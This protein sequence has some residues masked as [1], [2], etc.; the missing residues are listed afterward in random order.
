MA[1]ADWLGV[2]YSS[3]GAFQG[4][5]DGQQVVN[6]TLSGPLT[7][8]G[9]DCRKFHNDSAQAAYSFFKLDP[10]AHPTL[11]AIPDTKA[12]SLRA[13][14]RWDGTTACLYAENQI[15][16]RAKLG[17]S[18]N[19]SQGERHGY[20]FGINGG[21]G[22]NPAPFY[23]QG[24]N[25]TGA[26]AIVNTGSTLAFGT[27]AQIRMDVIPTSPSV[28]DTIRCYINTGTEASPVWTLEYERIQLASETNV[29][30]PWGDADYG[31]VGFGVRCYNGPVGQNALVHIDSF[32]ARLKDV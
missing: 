1:Y 2:H 4:G 31:N 5:L 23:W 32:D 9:A 15:C 6:S 12:I 25:K 10:T 29:W 27:W 17:L 18:T 8:S 28:S 11:T 24:G 20:S 22:L 13:W 19:T 26:N 16:L 3:P 14:V 30:I 21:C 7:L